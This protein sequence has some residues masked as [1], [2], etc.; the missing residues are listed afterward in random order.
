M[1]YLLKIILDFVRNNY[2]YLFNNL[3]KN[4]P[5]LLYFDSNLAYFDNKSIIIS[6]GLYCE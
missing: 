2:S 1:I 4:I 5:L 3:K 6:L